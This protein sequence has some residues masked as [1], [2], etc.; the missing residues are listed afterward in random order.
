M[1]TG[2]SYL[3]VKW[4]GCEAYVSPPYSGKVV[5]ERSYV[6]ILPTCIHGVCGL[7]FTFTVFK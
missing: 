3:G 7:N 4:P 1:H 5:N 2:G 6:P